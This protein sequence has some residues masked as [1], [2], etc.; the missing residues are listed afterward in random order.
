MVT[1]PYG[2]IPVA[3]CQFRFELDL[4]QSRVGGT[5]TLTG[6]EEAFQ[7]PDEVDLT[8]G[9]RIEANRRG[10]QRGISLS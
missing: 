4:C 3:T 8:W 5:R 2:F 9:A 7:P 10:R 1:Q 6:R